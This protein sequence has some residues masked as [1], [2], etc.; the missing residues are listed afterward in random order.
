MT[1]SSGSSTTKVAITSFCLFC[2]SLFLTAYTTKNPQVARVG[3]YVV[4]EVYRPF[5]VLGQGIYSKV[6]KV[7]H[8]YMD[9]VSVREE[10]DA[11]KSRLQQLENEVVSLQE[12][13]SENERFARM[14][15]FVQETKLDGLLAQVIGFSPSNWMQAITINK[16]KRDG[17]DVGMAAIAGSGVVGQV[18]EASRGTARI[19]L[20]TD[21]ISGVDAVVQESRARGVISGNGKG[22]FVFK[23][24]PR[25]YEVKTGDRIVTSGIGGVYQAGLLIGFV[26]D[27][28]KQGSLLFQEIEVKPAVDFS[29]VEE[30]Y[31]ARKKSQE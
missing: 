20:V 11:I 15:S 25:E 4:G 27:V 8:G 23:Y 28:K 17:V 9:L 6:S 31:I 29:R 18:I 7:W 14:L 3:Y 21:S 13:R 22:S 19:L 30:V 16:G 24:V 10:N 5:Q 2:C 1:A 12:V 26:S